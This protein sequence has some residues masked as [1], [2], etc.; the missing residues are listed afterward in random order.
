M[1]PLMVLLGQP[2]KTQKKH[3]LQHKTNHPPPKRHDNQDEE[4]LPSQIQH[5]EKEQAN[6]RWLGTHTL[7]KDKC[8]RHLALRGLSHS[9]QAPQR[10]W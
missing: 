1:P 10:P 3:K 8:A 2:E 7:E 6:L 9:T 4:I 5:A